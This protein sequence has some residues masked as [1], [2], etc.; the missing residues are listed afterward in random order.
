MSAQLK[1]SLLQLG[2]GGTIAVAILI[3]VFK[4]GVP[5]LRSRKN[6]IRCIHSPDAKAALNRNLLAAAAVERTELKVDALGIQSA[7]QTTHLGMIVTQGAKQT[8]L[9]QR[10]ADKK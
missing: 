3:V 7:Q 4:Y 2:V 1:S 10:I 5:A 6:G 9:L 8:E